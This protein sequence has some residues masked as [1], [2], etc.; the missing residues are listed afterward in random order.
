[1][2]ATTLQKIGASLV[3]ATIVTVAFASSVHFNPRTP[4]FTDN[5]TTLTACGRLVGLGNGDITITV[6][7][8]GTP[9]VTCTSPGGNQAPGQNPGTV[10]V[11]GGE[12]IPA[13]EIKNGSLSFCVTTEAPDQPTGKQAGCPNNNWTGAIT[14]VAFTTATI[15]VEQNN[16]VVLQQQFNLP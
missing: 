2:R 16:A 6:T 7:A 15:T 10:N 4:S 1:M 3:L 5:G 11:S 12:S 8:S 14:D 9:T 13:S